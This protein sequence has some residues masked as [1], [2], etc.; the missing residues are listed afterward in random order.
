MEFKD[1]E[2]L[3]MMSERPPGSDASLGPIAQRLP[4]MSLVDLILIGEIG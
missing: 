1:S 3:K 2:G 4:G